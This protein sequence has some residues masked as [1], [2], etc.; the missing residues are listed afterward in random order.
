MKSKGNSKKTLGK[1]VTGTPPKKP[2]GG[3]VKGK[4]MKGC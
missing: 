3:K 4:N 1:P 2:F